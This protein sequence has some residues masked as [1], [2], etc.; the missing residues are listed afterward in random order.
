MPG[1]HQDRERAQEFGQTVRAPRAGVHREMRTPAKRLPHQAR[2]DLVRADL[3]E[4]PHARRVHRLHLLGEP[5]GVHQLIEKP[6]RNGAGLHRVRRGGGVAENRKTQRRRHDPPER[7]GEHIAG[8]R[9]ERRVERALHRDGGRLEAMNVERLARPFDGRCQA[10]DHRLSRAVGIGEPDPIDCCDRPGHRVPV[11]RDRHHRP[12]IPGGAAVAGGARHRLAAV[13]R[14]IEQRVEPEGPR[15]VQRRQ[16]AIAVTRRDVR[17]DAEA[18]EKPHHPDAARPE[19]RLGDGRGCERLAGIRRRLPVERRR[20]EEVL[21]ERPRE[22]KSETRVGLR[23]SV[24]DLGELHR[25]L[26]HHV[27]QLRALPREQERQETRR[28]VPVA[29]MKDAVGPGSRGR[30]R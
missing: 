21:A 13:I 6:F 8:P 19:R 27:R 15:R 16:L 30:L 24:A 29:A 5:D 4:G 26:A 10:A 9:H 18:L 1:D 14:E 17:P 7:R 12:Q 28:S 11:A 2:Q 25:Q 22:A 23:Q 20:R 3:D